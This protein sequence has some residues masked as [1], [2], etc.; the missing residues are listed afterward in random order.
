VHEIGQRSQ[1]CDRPHTLP[2]QE[3]RDETGL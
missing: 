2:G 3:R 1:M